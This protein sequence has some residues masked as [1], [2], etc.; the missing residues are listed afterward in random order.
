[1][2]E[3]MT[4]EELRLSNE[5][6]EKRHKSDRTMWIITIVVVVLYFLYTSMYPSNEEYVPAN[7][8]C[9]RFNESAC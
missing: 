8:G 9:S 3:P 2:N 5:A 1:M 6:D 4:E 7:S